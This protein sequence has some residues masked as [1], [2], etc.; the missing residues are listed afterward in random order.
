MRYRFFLL[1]ALVLVTAGCN[2]PDAGQIS[3]VRN[4]SVLL[5]DNTKIR[6][7]EGGYMCP[8]SSTRWNGWGSDLHSYPDSSSQRQYKFS[9][10]EDADAPPIDGLRTKDGVKVRLAGT[11]Y[12]K[13]AFDCS[14]EGLRLLKKFDQAFVNRPEGQRPF[15]DWSQWLN[16]TWKPILDANARDVFLTLECKDVVSSCAL[17]AREGEVKDEDIQNADNKSNVARIETAMAEGLVAQLRAKLGEDYFKEITFNMEQPSLPEV[18]DAIAKA[19]QAFAKVADVRAERLSAQEQVKVEEQKR[20][21]AKKRSRAYAAC[22][23]CAR[24]DELRALG[25]S[26]PDGVTTVVLGDG[27]P[28]SVG[29]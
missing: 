17:L 3:V 24:Q 16:A 15:E 19:Q 14:S 29:R 10:D 18:E 23:S 2:G 4:G 5:P 1:A 28:V 27:A 20:L 21:A 7:G 13:T 22:P 12:M 26:L 6:D 9:D 11:F 8:G 25:D